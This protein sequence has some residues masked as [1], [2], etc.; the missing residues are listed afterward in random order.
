[1]EPNKLDKHIKEQL[2]SRE[3]QPS[4]MAWSKL[5]AML[6]AAESSNSEQAR[7][8]PKRKFPWMYI[9]ASVVGFLLIGTVYFSK[10]LNGIDN[11]NNEVVLENGIRTESKKE[12]PEVRKADDQLNEVI[13]KTDV[14][15]NILVNKTITSREKSIV[16][17]SI[18]NQ[19]PIV[20]VSINN[21]KL[22]KKSI[23]P[24]SVA[25]SVDELLA[26]VESPSKK[27]MQSQQ[28]LIVR[29]N[30]INLLSEIDGELELSFREKVINKVS[31]NFQTV[32]V[33]LSNRN[34]E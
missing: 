20:E 15:G 33:A 14:K 25:V 18:S 3:I 34:L 17:K 30:A 7:Q 21:Q 12:N 6:T 23:K 32:K 28:N 1:M 27:E 22:E 8:K 13:G 24:Q 4:E 26:A 11:L 2:N 5:D 9:A 10:K 29:V 19:N 31:K 16:N